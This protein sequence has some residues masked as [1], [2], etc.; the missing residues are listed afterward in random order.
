MNSP[1]TIQQYS[2]SAVALVSLVLYFVVRQYA[3]ETVPHPG[4]QTM[5]RAV[6]RTERSFSIIRDEKLRRG[7][8]DYTD[9]AR[10]KYPLLGIEFSEMTTTL[11]SHEAKIASSNPEFA[12]LVVRTLIDHG[13]DS[14]K[15]VGLTLSGSFPALG[16]SVL[17]ALEELGITPM[18]ISSLGASTYGANEPGMSWADIEQVLVS[19]HILTHRSL[20]MTPGADSDSGG[21]LPDGGIDSIKSIAARIGFSLRIPKSFNDAI[22]IRESIMTVNDIAMLINIGGNHAILGNCTHASSIPNGFHDRLTSCREQDRGL[23]MRLSEKGIPVL[24]LL[25]IK[26]LAQQYEIE[27]NGMNSMNSQKIFYAQTS[28]T[29]IVSVSFVLIAGLVLFF[30]VYQRSLRS[31]IR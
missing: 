6:E 22:A 4:A 16:I 5:A 24:H 7:L 29:F 20:V 14:T 8:L 26:N 30:S 27:E 15:T 12:A 2:L 10:M 19:H 13:V 9:A 18:I 3:V 31:K 21:G 1:S 25:N 23:L 17:C 28:D 11:G